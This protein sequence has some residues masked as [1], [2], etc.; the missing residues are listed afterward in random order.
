MN[1]TGTLINYY[2]HCT[3]QVWLFANKVVMEQNEDTVLSGKNLTNRAYEREK[4]EIRLEHNVLDFYDRKTHT[5]NEIKRS[6]KMSELHIRQVQFYMYQLENMGV[7]DI[8]G[9]IRYP[10]EKL[11]IDAVWNDDER[12]KIVTAIDNI[13]KILNESI[14]PPVI[15]KPYC[16]NCAYFDLCYS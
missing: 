7:N 15:D 12:A 6:S 9:K 16:K 4:H 13:K 8:K 14:P 5:I 3:R 1:I 11:V 2:F 10:T